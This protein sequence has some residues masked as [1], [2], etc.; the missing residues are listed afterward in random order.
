VLLGFVATMIR[1]VPVSELGKVTSSPISA[2]SHRGATVLSTF[3]C[4]S[5]LV[6]IIIA[7]F[8]QEEQL[9]SL[10]VLPMEGDGA[11]AQ[12][13]AGVGSGATAQAVDGD[14]AVDWSGLDL[15]MQSLRE[16]SEVYRQRSG[17]PSDLCDI[18]PGR[19]LSR[20]EFKQVWSAACSRGRD[21]G[22][23]LAS[24]IGQARWAIAHCG[25]VHWLWL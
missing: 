5:Y 13:G 16:R 4:F 9:Q 25:C 24:L 1:N 19:S 10:D 23:A 12:A 7:S 14:V 15:H 3:K 8:E 22:C 6:W 20:A 21:A 18:V 2:S 17:G 11:A